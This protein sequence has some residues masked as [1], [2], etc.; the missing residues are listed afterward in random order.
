[1]SKGKPLGFCRTCKS[2]IVDF[3][4]ESVFRDGECDA[5]EYMRYRTQP[6]LLAALTEARAYVA[7]MLAASGEDSGERMLLRRFDKI[8]RAATGQSPAPASTT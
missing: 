2:E 8:I 7:H 3:V 1:M 6:G 5:C 4:N